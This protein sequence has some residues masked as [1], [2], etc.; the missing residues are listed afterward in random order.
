[1]DSLYARYSN[2]LMS[3]AK[4]EKKVKEYKEA[5]AS[6]LDFFVSNK[7]ANTFLKSYFVSEEDKF[8]LIDKITKEFA[9]ISLSS[10]LKLLVKKHRLG[11]F[12]YIAHE[13]ISDCNEDLGVSEGIIY[14][15]VSLDKKQI[16]DIENAISKKLNQKVEL[17]NKI[18]ERLIG[19]VKV[20][21]HDHVFDGSIK[22]K[23][24]TMKTK[25]NERRS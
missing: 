5:I 1:M 21:V 16:S 2:A 20:V 24:E 3:L 6:L 7:D 22:N 25:L 17:S 18:D 8:S 9:L 13:F 23:L 14:S 15:T 10:F 4:E 19:G 12:K 11:S